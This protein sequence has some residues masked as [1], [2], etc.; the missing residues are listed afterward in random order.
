MS[1]MTLKLTGD[2]VTANDAAGLAINNHYIEHF[3]TGIHFH[4]T[5]RY[6]AFKSLV[7]AYQ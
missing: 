6:L 1:E 5:Q 4:I 2:Q 7:G 3:V